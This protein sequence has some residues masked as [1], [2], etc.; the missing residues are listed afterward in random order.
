MKRSYLVVAL[1]LSV[2]L[3][4]ASAN[5]QTMV[6]AKDTTVLLDIA[7]GFGSAKLGTDD[8]G[9]PQITGRMDGIA[10]R[11][12]FYGCEDGKDCT[13]LL[14]VAGWRT[15]ALTIDDVNRWNAEKRFGKAYIDSDG[16]PVMEMAVNLDFGLSRKNME[17]NFAWWQ[18]VIKSFR[19]DYIR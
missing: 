12:D 10:Y 1:V 14:F 17:D 19:D 8:Y 16:E 13:D 9:D 6:T 18:H 4:A 7:K 3:F 11:V 2:F 15:D 5:A